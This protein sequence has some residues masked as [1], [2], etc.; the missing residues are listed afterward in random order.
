MLR[1][2]RGQL[3]RQAQQHA[4]AIDALEAS[5]AEALEV[6]SA[7]HEMTRAK[8]DEYIAALSASEESFASVCEQLKAV[9]ANAERRRSLALPQ[10]ARARWVAVGDR[11]IEE[12]VRVNARMHLFSLKQ[13]LD[14]CLLYTSPSPRD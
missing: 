13:N 8:G 12:R 3:T 14:L 9:G 2:H 4:E 5:H 7:K 10:G 11:L 6:S 1:E